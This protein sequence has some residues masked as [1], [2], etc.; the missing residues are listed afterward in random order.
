MWT[1][2][3]YAVATVHSPLKAMQR[4]LAEPRPIKTAGRAVAFVGGLYALASVVLAAAGAVPL[5]PVL[6]LIRPENYYFWQTFFAV[7]FA[8]L[9]WAL[10]AGLIRLVGKREKGA[11]AFEKT[12]S[13]AGIALAASLFVAWIPMALTMLFMA[14]GMSQEEYVEMLSRPGAWQV[15]YVLLHLAAAAAAVFLL[16]L[17]AGEGHVRRTGCAKVWLAGILAAAVLSG[18]FALFIR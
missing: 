17:A 10:V 16:A 2:A 14:V 15:F 18:T 4:L 7:P 11:P 6:I 13:L 12:A 5:A 1:F 8:L 9:A 3:Y